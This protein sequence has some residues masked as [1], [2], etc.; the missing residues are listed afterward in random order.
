M[1]K[2]FI[3]SPKSILGGLIT[4]GFAEGFKKLGFYVLEK[5][6]QE[7]T[8]EDIKTF[9]PDYIF[10]YC[11]GYLVNQELSKDLLNNKDYKF[12]HYFADEPKSK[13]ASDDCPELYD[14]LK[15]AKKEVFI[16]DKELV[17]EFKNSHYLPLAVDPKLYKTSFEGYE[18]A[19]SFVGA[20]ITEKRQKIL[21]LLIKM[22]GKLSLYCREDHFQRSIDELL[23]NNLLNIEEIELYKK[24]YKGFISSEDEL[25]KVYNTTKVNINIT[26]QGKDNISYRVFEVLASSGFLLTDYMPEIY[27]HFEVGKEVDVY[28]NDYELID[29]I[30]FY[31]QN[32]NIA[33]SIARNGRRCVV[34]NH[35]FKQRAERII[36]LTS[37]QK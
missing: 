2:L 33:Q 16:W 10:G 8:F 9:N 3:T 6:V 5:D 22:Y 32:L 34:N 17:S 25:A 35:T 37:Q 28:Q 20:P 29:K 12:I 36:K 14:I 19:I 18:H 24:S 31:L 11:Y 23:K 30:D 1:Q 13:I 27:N 21:S 7:T 15:K 26:D 4:R